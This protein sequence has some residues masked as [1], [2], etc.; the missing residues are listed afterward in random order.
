MKQKIFRVLIIDDEELIRKICVRA[1]KT[2]GYELATAENAEEGIKLLKQKKYDLVISDMIM[3]GI[4][5]LGIVRWI[6]ENGPDIEIIIISGQ[7]T[8]EEMIEV[9]RLGIYDYIMKPFEIEKFRRVISHCVE[10]IFL[11]QKLKKYQT[12]D[13]LF[14]II[15]EISKEIDKEKI[16]NHILKTAMKFLSEDAGS[17][18]LKDEKDILKIIAAEGL[19][20]EIV[21]NTYEHIGEGIAGWVA[22]ENKPLLLLNGLKN[23]PEFIHFNHDRNIK[24]SLSVPLK[25]G[26]EIIGVININRMNENSEDFDEEDLKLLTTFAKLSSI[27]YENS[28]LKRAD[29]NK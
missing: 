15:I 14:E 20:E 11:T 25:I 18:M 28:K 24:S 22:K 17:I 10:K 5:G 26:D 19:S 4:G 12:I 3:P 23:Y 8:I 9:M 29:K 1:L 27:I 6:K 2:S 21:Q 16:M 7:A 13:A